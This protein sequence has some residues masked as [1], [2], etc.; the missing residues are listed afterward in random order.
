MDVRTKNKKITVKDWH[1]EVGWPVWAFFFELSVIQSYSVILELVL[2]LSRSL[3]ISIK[4]LQL[5]VFQFDTVNRLFCIPEISYAS[6][7]NPDKNWLSRGKKFGYFPSVIELQPQ[8]VNQFMEVL[9][10]FESPCAQQPLLRMTKR[11]KSFS[12]FYAIWVFPDLQKLFALLAWLKSIF[13]RWRH[14]FC[15]EF[16]NSLLVKMRKDLTLFMIWG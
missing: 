2:V 8:R 1:R 11:K 10:L 16:F 5:V 15:Q 3:L 14:V 4:G 6:D 13:S 12:A 9:H 7:K